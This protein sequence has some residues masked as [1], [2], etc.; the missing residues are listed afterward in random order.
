VRA[1]DA[2]GLSREKAE[3]ALLEIYAAEGSDWFWWYGPDFSTENDALFDDLF[4]QHL[5][6]VYTL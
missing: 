4:R 3:A 6:N 1:L 2:G 5:K